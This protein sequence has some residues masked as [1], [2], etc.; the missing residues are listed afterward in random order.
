VDKLL[1]WDGANNQYRFFLFPNGT[2]EFQ[3]RGVKPHESSSGMYNGGKN[4]KKTL[5]AE[6]TADIKVRQSGYCFASF[7]TWMLFIL[8]VEI[9][10]SFPLALIVVLM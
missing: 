2:S 9:S 6:E 5:T 3:Y 10:F 7:L 4:V 1:Y 8:F